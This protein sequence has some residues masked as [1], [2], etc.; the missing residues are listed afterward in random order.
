M[1][2]DSDLTVKQQREKRRAEKVAALKA[3]QKREKRSRILAIALSVVAVVAVLGVVITIVVTNATRPP[4]QV[5]LTAA[6]RAG[7][8]IVDEEQYPGLEGIH[9]T[10]P[11]SYE[12]SPPA[13]GPHNPSWLNCGVYEEE[14]PTEYAVHSMEHGAVWVAYDPEQVSGDA[15]STLRSSVP[16]RHIIVSPVAG[17]ESPV[18]ASAWGARVVLDGVEDERLSQFVDKYWLSP[19]APEPGALCSN[20]LEGPGRVS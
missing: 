18:I 9:T 16:D 11:V 13:G 10:D 1:S 3:K 15:L 14:V 6:E 20:A 8:E 7:I 2:N 5:P 4:V 12:T 19:T 17:L